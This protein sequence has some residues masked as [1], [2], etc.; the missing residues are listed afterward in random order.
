MLPF[1]VKANAACRHHATGIVGGR[2]LGTGRTGLGWRLVVWPPRSPSGGFCCR[3]NF[4]L[5]QPNLIS[6][7]RGSARRQTQEF[8][9][10]TFHDVAHER[11]E[12]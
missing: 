12:F 11:R 7:E 1:T 2:P 10:G 9:T 8:P 6:R 5:H 3:W 4:N